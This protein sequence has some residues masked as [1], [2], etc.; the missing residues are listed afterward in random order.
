MND[1]DP[2]A[3]YRAPSIWHNIIARTTWDFSFNYRSGVRYSP[4]KQ[5]NDPISLYSST[6]IP[7]GRAG[8]REG[9]DFLEVNIGVSARVLDFA[10][11][12]LSVRFEVLNLFDRDNHLDVYPTTGEPDNTG[13]LNTEPGQAWAENGRWILPHDS[14]DLTGTEK[15]LLK[16][17]D[18]SN[19]GRP[20]IFRL[21]AK[22]E[23]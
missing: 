21:L 12:A 20:R 8:S 18:P 22:L 13:W 2:T 4:M 6:F 23:F 1:Y 15:Y 3:P 16:Q 9:K 14:S 5:G 11:A 7:D 19:F 17:N 10:G